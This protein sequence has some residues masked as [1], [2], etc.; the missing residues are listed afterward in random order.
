MVSQARKFRCCWAI[1]AF[2][3][4]IQPVEENPEKGKDALH[5]AE[6]MFTPITRLKAVIFTKSYL[7]AQHS[8]YSACSS[9]M[10]LKMKGVY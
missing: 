5:K 9:S 2:R 6:S 3:L 7:H 8:L 4:K 10:Y 1:G